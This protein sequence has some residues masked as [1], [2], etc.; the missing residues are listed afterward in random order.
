MD[1]VRAWSKDLQVLHTIKGQRYRILLDVYI[2]EELDLIDDQIEKIEDCNKVM[3]TL[4]M[5]FHRLKDQA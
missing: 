4:H 2:V 1:E 3:E 5:E